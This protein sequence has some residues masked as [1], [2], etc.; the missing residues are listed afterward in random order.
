MKIIRGKRDVIIEIKKEPVMN[1]YNLQ[2]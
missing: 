2:N 1:C